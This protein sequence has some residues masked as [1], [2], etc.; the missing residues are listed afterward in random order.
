MSMNFNR[1]KRSSRTSLKQRG[2]AKTTANQR[3]KIITNMP[4]K[5]KDIKKL[6]ANLMNRKD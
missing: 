3:P 2:L 6:G 1:N 4:K 5:F